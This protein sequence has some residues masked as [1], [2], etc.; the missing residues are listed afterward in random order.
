MSL[1]AELL[2]RLPKAELHVHLD[3]CVRPGTML[4]LAAAQ[5]V[6]LPSDDP[7]TLADYMLVR[8]ARSLEE[9]LDR[10][11]VTLAV[12]Q[13]PEALERIAREF[14]VDSAADGVRYVEVR[15]CPALHTPAMSPADAVEAPLAGLRAGEAEVPAPIDARLIVCGLRTLAPAISR[16]MAELAVRYR[17]RGV[18]AFDLAGAEGGH[19]AR[20][21]AEAFA[22][23]RAG[24]LAL[25]C[26]AGEGAGAESIREALDRCH[27]A[28]IGHGVRLR[29]DPALF[30]RV[31]DAGIPLEMC[32]TS[33]VH[34]RT[35]EDL[36]SH[37]FREYFDAGI[38]VTLNT[39]S[40]LMDRLTLSEEYR[41]VCDQFAFT[42]DELARLILHG[43]EQAFLPA[44]E[45]DA[46]VAEVRQS[47]RAAA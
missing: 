8:D 26:H 46:L 17:E 25:T 40:R 19:P 42:R 35:V 43:F 16:Q 15:Y 10:Y 47:L 22:I 7:D 31:R 41:R 5:G 13:T 30:A 39:D 36:A 14:V 4:E 18:V 23:A 44:A 9:Y 28:R 21:H 20:E 29:E 27:A 12:M 45:R 33:N 3:G 24:G 32:P 6:A 38:V 34:T 2:R 1:P 11:Q 37:P